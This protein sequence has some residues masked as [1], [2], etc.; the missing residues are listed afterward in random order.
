M[1][2]SKTVWLKITPVLFQLK[3]STPGPVR[4][5]L[6]NANSCW[7]RLVYFGYCTP[8]IPTRGVQ[9]PEYRNWLWQ[10]LAFFNRMEQDQE[11]IFSIGTGPEQKQEWFL[12]YCFWDINVYLHSTRF[13]TE[14]KQEQETITFF[15]N[16]ES[17]RIKSQILKHRS[18]VGVEKTRIRKPLIPTPDSGIFIKTKSLLR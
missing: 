4:L 14:V 6:K 9:E 3:K 18:G 15:W 1:Q 10:E 13:V 11:W 8:L 2:I 7:S 17:S 5:L 16:Q 12:P